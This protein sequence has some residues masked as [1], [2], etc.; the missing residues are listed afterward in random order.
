[1]S[2]V[3]TQ[4]SEQCTW[5]SQPTESK[6]SKQIYLHMLPVTRKVN[7]ECIQRF[8]ICRRHTSTS[9]WKRGVCITTNCDP[10]FGLYCLRVSHLDSST[11]VGC[12]LKA[13][14]LKPFRW[15]WSFVFKEQGFICRKKGQNLVTSLNF[16][17]MSSR[18]IKVNHAQVFVAIPAWSFFFREN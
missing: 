18:A 1:M 8:A 17:S 14:D 3:H 16:C 9:E 5:Y 12:S 11:V 7:S 13:M 4:R 15:K 2:L 6:P 10:Y